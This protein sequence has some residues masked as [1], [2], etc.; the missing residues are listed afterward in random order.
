MVGRVQ[1]PICDADPEIEVDWKEETRSPLPS[2]EPT[3]IT[4]MLPPGSIPVQCPVC[5]G[6]DARCIVCHGL[7][8]I[9]S[10]R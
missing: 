9:R 4:P 3:A 10:A 6:D 7:G 1:C 8:T 2:A 5:A